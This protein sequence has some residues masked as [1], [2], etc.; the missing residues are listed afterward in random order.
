MSAPTWITR[1]RSRPESIKLPLM[2]SEPGCFLI[3][4]LS[5]VSR[6]SFTSASPETTTASAG[7]WSPRPKRMMSSSTIWS[8]SSS[9]SAPS[10][11]AMAFLEVSSVSLST[12]F[13]ERM[14]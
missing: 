14:D 2:S 9:T 5:P 6:L 1:A 4:S 10:R 7:I 8:R 12:I 13:L 11:T 3:R